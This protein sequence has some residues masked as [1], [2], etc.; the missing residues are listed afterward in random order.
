MTFNWE[1]SIGDVIATFSLIGSVLMYILTSVKQKKT[2]DFAK[3]A[4]AYNE[5]AKK[6]YD[7]MVEQ[8]K[9]N[10][11]NINKINSTT[12]TNKAYCD[13]NIIKIGRNSW[14]LKI[15]NK[16]NAIAKDISFEFLIDE[17]PSI[18][19]APGTSFPIKLLEP[20][21][22]VDYHLGI[23]LGL[24]TH[25]WEYQVTWTNQDGSS[26]SKKGILTLP[27]S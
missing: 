22:N 4:N 3:N 18:I 2:K 19:A 11:E 27:L 16:G 9:S 5:S 24:S 26:D 17:K 13:A 6:Y 8:I 7:L 25:S 15:F 14:I 23:Y 10:N 20:Q 1:I 12:K 21:R